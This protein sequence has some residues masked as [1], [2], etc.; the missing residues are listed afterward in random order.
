[1]SME[2]L[3]HKPVIIQS[4]KVGDSKI[5]LGKVKDALHEPIYFCGASSF[6]VEGGAFYALKKFKDKH[7]A[8]RAYG[9]FAKEIA[10]YPCDSFLSL[11][12]ADYFK[13]FYEKSDCSPIDTYKTLA[14]R[15]MVVDR[16]FALE[17]ET[18]AHQLFLCAEEPHDGS[19]T[20]FVSLLEGYE[21]Y[22]PRDYY[23]GV[24][25]D[26]KLPLWAK[27]R[28]DQIRKKYRLETP[29]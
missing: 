24:M 17:H 13:P 5:I 21:I 8:V 20:A 10:I 29:V 2:I 9:D 6:E 23:L 3:N 11:N 26:H 15:V 22:D 18:G 19:E 1:M 12:D 4:V 16:C 14:G 28:A 25:E 27:E 7:E